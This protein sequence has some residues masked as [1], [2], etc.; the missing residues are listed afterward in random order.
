MFTYYISLYFFYA[1]PSHSWHA[2]PQTAAPYIAIVAYS[3]KKENRWLAK[4]RMDPTHKI[5][6]HA[7]IASNFS[8]ATVTWKYMLAVRM[9]DVPWTHDPAHK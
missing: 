2:I 8:M 6:M 7:C 3:M 1:H 9:E 5:K 4:R